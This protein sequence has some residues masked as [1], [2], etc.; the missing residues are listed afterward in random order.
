MAWRLKRL[1]RRICIAWEAVI[2]E[3]LPRACVQ[4]YDANHTSKQE[5]EPKGCSHMLPEQILGLEHCS[6][7]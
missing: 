6:K 4:N 7:P 2:L 1:C 3:S 5:Y